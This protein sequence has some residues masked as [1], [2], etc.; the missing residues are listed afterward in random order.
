MTLITSVGWSK[1][2]EE[3]RGEEE[4]EEEEGGVDGWRYGGLWKKTGLYWGRERKK[5]Q[6]AGCSL[7]ISSGGQK[8]SKKNS[9][10]R[11]SGEPWAP[12]YILLA[13]YM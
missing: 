8:I 12:E 3:T 10:S 4:E 6:D 11:R 1:G 2:K 9:S 7:D 13:S 5:F